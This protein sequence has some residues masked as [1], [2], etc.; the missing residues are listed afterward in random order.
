MASVFADSP[1]HFVGELPQPQ[2]WN[3]APM[4]QAF[5]ILM[6]AHREYP[7][8]TVAES[9]GPDIEVF[10][11]QWRSVFRRAGIESTALEDVDLFAIR[12]KVVLVDLVQ[13]LPR[14]R[15]VVGVQARLT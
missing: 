8:L 1:I 2:T 10:R 5:S 6:P 7:G 13:L 4:K 15:R 3:N 11:T 14:W 9:V 12:Q